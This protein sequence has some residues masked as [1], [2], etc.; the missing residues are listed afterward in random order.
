MTSTPW[1]IN[2]WAV[3][4]THLE[5]VPERF[6]INSALIVL[7]VLFSLLALCGRLC[8]DEQ[9]EIISCL[10][11]V[12]KLLFA[13]WKRS[14]MNRKHPIND[15][16][17]EFF[18]LNYIVN[19]SENKSINFLLEILNEPCSNNCQFETKTFVSRWLNRHNGIEG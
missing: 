6:V 2:Q 5:G 12:Y 18:L 15:R 10:L 11:K 13:T 14:K 9:I 16:T 3:T 1:T 7:Y 4:K 17:V 8:L 19:I